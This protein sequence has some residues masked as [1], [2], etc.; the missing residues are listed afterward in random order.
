M[1]GSEL[2]RSARSLIQLIESDPLNPQPYCMLAQVYEAAREFRKAELVLRQAVDV[3]PLHAQTWA[4]LGALHSNLGQW[5]AAVDAFEHAYAL[6]SL[7][8]EYL[9]GYGLALIATQDLEGAARVSAMLLE[10]FSDRSHSHVIAG[11]LSKVQGL[12]DEASKSYGR[13]LQIDPGQTDAAYNLADLAPPEAADPL[14][15]RLETLRRDPALS[16]REVANICFALARVYEQAGRVDLAYAAL[17]DA[18]RAAESMMARLGHD[19][20]PGALQEQSEALIRMFTPDVF[21]SQLEPI[22]LDLKLIFIVGLPRSG[23]TLVERIL[24]SHSQVASGGELPFMQECLVKYRAGRQ[25]LGHHGPIAVVNDKERQLLSGLREEYLDRIFERELDRD[26]VVDKLPAN[27]AALGLI[28]LLFPSA[29]IVHCRRDPMATC[30][31]LYAAHF[32]IHTPYNTSFERIAHYYGIYSRLMTHWGNVLVPA[33]TDVRYEDVVA[34]PE[35]SARGL[36]SECGLPWEDSCVQFHTNGNPAY[37]ASMQQVRQPVYTTS[38]SRWRKFEKHLLPLAN[39]LS[40]HV[41][42]YRR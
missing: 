2:S 10:R 8:P 33:I 35:R 3:A 28:R 20:D 31:S 36:L 37:T 24:S 34:D 1:G 42:A 40:E 25:A 18:N 41:R 26:Y 4:R 17:Q 19:Y 13:A 23:T 21:P 15:A 6:D 32:G 22:D 14:T 7:D 29:I 5:Q 11:H 12:F 27:F 16:S 9:S 38:V 30:W 39:A